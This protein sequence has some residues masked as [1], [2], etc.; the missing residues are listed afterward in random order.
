MCAVGGTACVWQWRL[1]CVG[2]VHLR[3]RGRRGGGHSE[4]DELADLFELLDDPTKVMPTC[5]S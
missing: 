3:L 4:T 2:A 1:T 5:A